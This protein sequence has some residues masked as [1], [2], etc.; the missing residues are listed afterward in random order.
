MSK[1][2][3]SQIIYLINF[4]GKPSYLH[5]LEGLIATKTREQIEQHEEW[6]KTYLNLN[7]LKKQAIK[8]WKENKMVHNLKLNFF[9]Y[10]YFDKLDYLG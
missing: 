2:G 8:Q 10:K 6:Y 7:D 3:T 1:R 9:Y 4:K 5:E